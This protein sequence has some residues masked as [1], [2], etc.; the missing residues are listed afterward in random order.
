MS[1]KAGTNIFEYFFLCGR[2]FLST[3]K[4]PPNLKI[5]ELFIKRHDRRDSGQTGNP[6]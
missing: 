6:M 2:L 4:S 5:E 3:T 1:A